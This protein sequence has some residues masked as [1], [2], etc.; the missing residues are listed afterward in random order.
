MCTI[1]DIKK[2]NFIA[3][4]MRGKYLRLV[5]KA[6]KQNH[7]INPDSELL[8]II[9]KL[10]EIGFTKIIFYSKFIHSAHK[11]VSIKSNR[12]L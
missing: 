4:F 11:V 9:G 10:D 1:N 6:V 5:L 3:K 12:Q 8:Y 7:Y 2:I